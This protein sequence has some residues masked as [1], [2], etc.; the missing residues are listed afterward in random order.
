MSV[1]KQIDFI[2]IGAA[3]SGSSW[4]NNILLQHPQIE[5]P[6]RKE[7]TFFNRLDISGIV[8]KNFDNKLDYYLQFWDFNLDKTRGEFSPQYLSDVEAPKRIKEHFPN[9][10]LIVILRNPVHRALSHLEYDQHFNAVIS[11]EIAVEDAFKKHNYLL[12]AGL[13]A[14]HLKRWFDV[15]AKE[16]I[17]I[18]I[19]EEAV[20]NPKQA[21][22]DLF[23]FLGVT[24]TKNLDFSAINE[25]KE[26]KSSTISKLLKVPGK[27][28]KKLEKLDSWK[29]VKQ[30]GFYNSLIDAKTYLVD[31]NAQKREKSEFTP[32]VYSTLNEYYKEPKLELEKLLDIELGSF[33]KLPNE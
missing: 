17:K 7:L 23:K 13:Y 31:K 27:I 8:N 24:T 5:I 19:F 14:N 9:A 33:W 4:L 10:K 28:D 12:T 6:T 22:T 25:R 2:G 3:K 18:I 20:E 16:Q 29:K 11:K 26:I 30:S 21:S 1:T 32:E 15:F